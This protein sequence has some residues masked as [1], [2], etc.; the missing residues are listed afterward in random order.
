MM[1]A[2]LIALTFMKQLEEKW[3]DKRTTNESFSSTEKLL[4]PLRMC[5]LREAQDKLKCKL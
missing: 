2:V 1:D 5:C 3:I 4:H